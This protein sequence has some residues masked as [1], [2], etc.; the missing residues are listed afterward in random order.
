MSSRG[1]ADQPPVAS[2]LLPAICTPSPPPVLQVLIGENNN[3]KKKKKESLSVAGISEVSWRFVK[4]E[5]PSNEAGCCAAGVETRRHDSSHDLHLLLRQDSIAKTPFPLQLRPALLRRPRNGAPGPQVRSGK[6]PPVLLL[7]L[8]LP[9][10]PSPPSTHL[11]EVRSERRG[12]P[13]RARSGPRRGMERQL[14][15][16]QTRRD[17]LP[18]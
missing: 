12:G 17:K 7:V 18:L 4:K 1:S 5:G 2:F 11:A 13:R 16:S 14:E 6:N 10:H 9:L 15:P 8:V 3:G